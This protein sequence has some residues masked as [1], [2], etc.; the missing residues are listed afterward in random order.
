M[1]AA[2]RG[3]ARAPSKR[4][5]PATPRAPPTRR[6]PSDL[7]PRSRPEIASPWRRRCSRLGL[8]KPKPKPNPNPNGNGN[9]N[10]K[11]NANANPNPNPNPS[12]NPDPNPY[13]SPTP[14]PSPNPEQVLLRCHSECA[15]AG[16]VASAGLPPSASA[17]SP[18]SACTL[19]CAQRHLK[20]NP[21]RLAAVAAGYPPY[22]A[23][24][25]VG[26]GGNG[27]GA[28]AARAAGAAEGGDAAEA[29]REGGTQRRASAG[30]P[31]STGAPLSREERAT[32]LA[33]TRARAEAAARQVRPQ[34]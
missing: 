15:A 34:P 9:G 25:A 1:A 21:A 2:R 30:Y 14:H 26:A 10:A 31:P 4:L 29:R 5:A 16:A 22:S 18:P 27:A 11:A 33:H 7:R 12:P 8:A 28:D 17:G 19:A 32:A 6:S 13:P 23:S 24:T 3:R 20:N